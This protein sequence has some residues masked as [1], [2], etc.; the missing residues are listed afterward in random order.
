MKYL[1]RFS[2]DGS[3]FYGFQRQKDK[4]T[5]QG[6]I[7]DALLIIN[8]GLV[9]IKGAGRTDVGVHAN[10]QCAHFSL[11]VLIPCNRLKKALNRIL[12][13]YIDVLEVL[14][15]KDDFHARFSVVKKR[16]VYKIWLGDYSPFKYNYYLMYDKT[17]DLEKLEECARLFQG[18][19]NFHNFVAGLRKNYDMDVKN[20][21][22]IKKKEEVW[23]VFE[24]KSFYRYMV[25]NLVGAMLDYN[26]GKCDNNT[27][28][29]MLNNADFDFKLRTAVSSGLYLDGVYYE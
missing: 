18:R 25:R 22:I 20:I 4:V 21:K 9:E 16:Y 11:D 23:I 1:I 2:Y 8:K 17:L 7:E 15:V 5:V 13:P 3:R 24:G 6:A 27:L 28:K 10:G 19:H 29:K 26:E 12:H 14:E